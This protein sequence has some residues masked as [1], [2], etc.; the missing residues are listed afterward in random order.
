MCTGTHTHYVETE[1]ER[2]RERVEDTLYGK[3]G[4]LPTENNDL[5]K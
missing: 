2:E 4:L 1:R 5:T 3:V